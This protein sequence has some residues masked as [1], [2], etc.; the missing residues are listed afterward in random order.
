MHLYIKTYDTRCFNELVTYI[1]RL[2]EGILYTYSIFVMWMFISKKI[3]NAL[4]EINV[5][6]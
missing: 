4:S 1:W 3:V 2:F 6:T 5:F